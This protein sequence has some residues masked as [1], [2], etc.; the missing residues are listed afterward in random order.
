MITLNISE[1]CA[2][3]LRRALAVEQPGWTPSQP[4]VTPT[5]PAQPPVTPAGD[6]QA[7]AHAEA[8]R[9]HFSHAIL[10]EWDWQRGGLVFD[11]AAMGQVR[12]RGIVIISFVPTSARVRNGVLA[13]ATAIGY[14][15]PNQGNQLSMSLSAQ[16]CDFTV[17]APALSV[18][19]SPTIPYCVGSPPVSWWNQQPQAVGLTAGQ[20]Y[21]L[22]CTGR[23]TYQ[24]GVHGSGEFRVEARVPQGH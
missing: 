22:N 4:P 1:S 17:A 2:T 10:F 8:L 14:P 5:S 16:P 12:E 24:P 13:Q 18:G 11:T 23:D 20:R 6:W 19:D 7:Q 9:Q 3:E 21:Y 15:A